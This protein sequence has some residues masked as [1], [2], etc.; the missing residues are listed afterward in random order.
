MASAVPQV[1]QNM[2]SALAPERMLRSG[3]HCPKEDANMNL[4]EGTRRLALLLGVVGAI[5]G[6]GTTYIEL[7]AALG[8]RAQHIRFEQLAALDCIQR[9]RQLIRKDRSDAIQEFIAL[10]EDRQMATLKQ[11]PP[12]NQNKLLA[13]IKQR[14]AG[15]IKAIHWTM[16]SE[17]ESIETK[18]GQTIYP[19]PSPGAWTYLL[20]ALF[21]VLGFF[22]PWSAIRAIGWVGAGFVKP[23]N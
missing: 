8:Q 15:G 3:Y 23:V 5:L 1:G 13:E 18:D 19:T 4:R 11:L 7:H 6:G 17:I 14:T 12:E 16:D 9:E 10:P 2:K 21:P 20:I 22:I